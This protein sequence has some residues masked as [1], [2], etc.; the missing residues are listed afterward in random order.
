MAGHKSGHLAMMRRKCMITE[1]CRDADTHDC[2]SI[3]E[4][5]P[6]TSWLAGEHIVLCYPAIHAPIRA[7]QIISTINQ[8]APGPKRSYCTMESTFALFQAHRN[9]KPTMSRVTSE[10]DFRLS[11]CSRRFLCPAELR[12]GPVG[13][14]IRL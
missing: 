11:R 1:N 7:A 9:V 5:G 10:G 2:I 4:N 6:R 13:D 3:A 12:L 14:L 8:R